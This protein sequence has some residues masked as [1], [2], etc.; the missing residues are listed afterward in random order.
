MK[1]ALYLYIILV[2]VFFGCQPSPLAEVP[3]PPSSEDQI[4]R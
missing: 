1:K 4:P 2:F 3:P